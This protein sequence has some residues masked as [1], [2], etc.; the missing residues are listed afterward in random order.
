[1]NFIVAAILWH[2]DE[3]SAFWIFVRLME[4]HELRDNYL[5]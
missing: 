4:D 2:A 5:P 1:M 3:V